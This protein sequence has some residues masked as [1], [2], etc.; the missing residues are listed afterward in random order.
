MPEPNQPPPNS[1][2]SER[3]SAGRPKRKYYV[4]SGKVS[5]LVL[6]IDADV[7]ALRFVQNALKGAMISGRKQVNKELRLLDVEAMKLLAAVRLDSQILVSES[8][9]SS[10]EAGAYATAVVIKRWR[11][12]IAAL[13]N[14]IR[15]TS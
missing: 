15:S 7:A 6:A 5:W 14:L 12:Q 9:F 11:N 8:G 10:C 2:V 4:R 13:E 3:R 1:P